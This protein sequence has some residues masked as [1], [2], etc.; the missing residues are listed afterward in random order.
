MSALPSMSTRM[1]R[2]EP[3]RPVQ[4]AENSLSIA[5]NL[6]DSAPLATVDIERAL[7]TA[8]RASG[9]SESEACRLMNVDASQWSKQKKN[10]DNAHVSLQRLMKLPRQFWLELLQQIAEPLGIVV[11]HPDVADRALS[12]LLL[13][14]EAAVTYAKQDRAL[15]AGG[16]R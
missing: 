2:V 14:V 7:V 6:Q 1:A 11:A 13:S 9:L 10:A 15:R 4:S 12:Q 5:S 16:M 8:L 3:S